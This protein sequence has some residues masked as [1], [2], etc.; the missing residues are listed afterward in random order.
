[1]WQLCELLYTCYSLT[2]LLTY[3]TNTTERCGRMSN[4]FDH[5]FFSFC[6]P[7]SAALQPQ[8][9]GSRTRLQT[10]SPWDFTRQGHRS[11]SG[12][13]QLAPVHNRSANVRR[14]AK[15]LSAGIYKRIKPTLSSRRPLIRCRPMSFL[16]PPSVQ[17]TTPQDAAKKYPPED[18]WQYF[19]AD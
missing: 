14:L 7:S 5:L 4:N 6:R 1:M 19:P 16:G 18:F 12:R 11:F 9:S 15:Q 10:I 13:V 17:L 3:L 8:R 2:Y